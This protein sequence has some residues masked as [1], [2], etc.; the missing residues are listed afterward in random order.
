MQGGDCPS[1]QTTN[2]LAS[3]NHK[4]GQL[5]PVPSLLVFVGDRP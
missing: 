2:S 1:A 4:R 3:L 5:E